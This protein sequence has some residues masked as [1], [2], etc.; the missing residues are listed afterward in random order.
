MKLQAHLYSF[1][2]WIFPVILNVLYPPNQI[3]SNTIVTKY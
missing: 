3:L 1:S 2:F